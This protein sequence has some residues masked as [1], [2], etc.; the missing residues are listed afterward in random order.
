M[1]RFQVDLITADGS[2]ETVSIEIEEMLGTYRVTV[3][4][5]EQQIMGESD[6]GFFYALL[7]VRIALE[8]KGV[9]LHCFGASEDVW[10]SGMQMSMGPGILAFR[11]TLGRQSLSKDI[12]H[13]FESDDAVK[14]ATVEQQEAFNRR[15]INSLG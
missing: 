15:W 10:Q 7:K 11:T 12:V 5:G 9:L 4:L 3:N 13:I 6:N 8:R 1:E 14:P 2:R